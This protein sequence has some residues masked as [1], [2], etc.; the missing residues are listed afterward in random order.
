MSSLIIPDVPVGWKVVVTPFSY[1]KWKQL[2]YIFGWCD[3]FNKEIV[4]FDFGNTIVNIILKHEAGH[5]W[6]IDGCK[7]MW[8]LM[9]E[10]DNWFIERLAI[11]PQLLFGIRPCKA[12][13]G[14]IREVQQE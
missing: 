5:A 3:R 7:K 4:A 10:S 12:C 13:R 14:F 9:F 6:G 8:C 11:I 2:G 1:R